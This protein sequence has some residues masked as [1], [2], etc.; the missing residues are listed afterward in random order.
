MKSIALPGSTGSIGR[1]VLDVVSRLPE[2][3]RVVS[4]AANRNVELLAQQAWQFHPSLV[5][6][7]TADDADRLRSA[8]TVQRSP[9]TVH[10]GP[11]GLT[12]AAT[13]PEADIVV[14][15]VAGTV[16]LAP[17]IE[18]IKAGK[19]IALAS[20]E[21]LVAAGSIVTR[22]AE[23]KGVRLLPIDS[24]HSAIFQCLKGE[25]RGKIR[26]LILTASGGAFASHPIETLGQVTVEQ[27]LAHPT[28]SMGRKITIDSAT[29]M[30][31]ALEIIEAHWLFGVDADRI[32][33]VIHP[34]S[35]VHSMVE[36][37]DGSIMA[38]LGIPDMR[39]PIQYALLYPERVDT[40][41]P[42]LDIAAQG[43][44]TFAR[45]DPE[46]YPSLGLAYE[47][48]RIG[49]TMPAVLNA[50][51]ETAVALFLDGK[52]GFLGIY[53]IVRRVS[54]R[55]APVPDPDLDQILEADAWARTTAITIMEEALA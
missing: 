42:R 17:T 46:R 28:W 26:R 13:I 1:Q 45:P 47:A 44:L 2:R 8:C 35:I 6:V 14:V 36:F 54:E 23:E 20:K 19:D 18:A 48:M 32:E 43:T 55:H 11:D 9:F 5:S 24:E 27:A 22:I 30:N 7:G 31:K 53:E 41:L 16:G 15:A 33:V 51:N 21:V 38:Q 25:D 49:G 37:E 29:L 39:L 50:A 12:R 4:L 40:G 34:Q 52:I 3:L 10:Y